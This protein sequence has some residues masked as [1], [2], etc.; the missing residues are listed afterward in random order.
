MLFVWN[1]VE[2]FSICMNIRETRFIF[3][4]EF[5]FSYPVAKATDNIIIIFEEIA[6]K[7]QLLFNLTHIIHAPNSIFWKSFK[8]DI[9]CNIIQSVILLLL[10]F[11]L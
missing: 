10:L 3:L 11:T 1:T 9:Q 5:K 4:Y 2:S 7:E 8:F 6:N